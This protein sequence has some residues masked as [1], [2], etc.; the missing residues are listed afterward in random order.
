MSTWQGIDQCDWK[1]K[2]LK[3]VEEYVLT[4][5]IEE[6]KNIKKCNT[7]L[8]E[9]IERELEQLEKI[10]LIVIDILKILRLVQNLEYIHLRKQKKSLI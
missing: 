4:K 7:S 3:E 2:L 1:P 8:N 6:F 5:I 9:K 10:S